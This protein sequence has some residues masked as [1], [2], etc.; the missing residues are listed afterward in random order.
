MIGR[1]MIRQHNERGAVL[2]TGLM[3]LLILTLIGLAAM[4][5]TTLQ[6]KMAGNLG[7]R[8]M[9]FHASEAA[10]RDG[11]AI[12][13]TASLA[14][15][16]GLTPGLY[17]LTSPAD[18]G[19]LDWDASD[20]IAYTGSLGDL[21]SAPR[22]IVEDLGPL[23]TESDSFIAGAP[24]PEDN[25]FRVTARGVGGAPGAVAILQSTYLR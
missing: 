13:Q 11:E 6:Q 23:Q 15:F 1:I 20:S 8:S 24:V 18:I 7:N 5:T 19:A 3:I 16:D 9:A 21:A 2:I 17:S 12:V 22:Y 14:S 10:L 4:Q 25:M